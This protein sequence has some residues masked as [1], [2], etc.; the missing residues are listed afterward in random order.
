[1]YE[2]TRQVKLLLTAVVVG[3]TLGY[4]LL[5]GDYIFDGL[6]IT[7]WYCCSRVSVP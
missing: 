1:M 7:D 6:L 5:V 3:G 4:L 2:V